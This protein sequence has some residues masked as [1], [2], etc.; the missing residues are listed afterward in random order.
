MK[1]MINQYIAALVEYGLNCQLISLE[2]KI[3]TTNLILEALHLEDYEEPESG[4]E[5]LQEIPLEEILKGICDYAYE[6]D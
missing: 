2:D 6:T 1:D 4:T 5:A 3:Y